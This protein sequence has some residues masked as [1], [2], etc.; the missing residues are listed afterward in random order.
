MISIHQP[1]K[2]KNLYFLLFDPKKKKRGM[3]K[4]VIQ[5]QLYPK[6]Q[7]AMIIIQQRKW[8]GL[9]L[10]L[11]IENFWKKLLGHR[12]TINPPMEKRV[13]IYM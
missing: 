12:V 2:N 5:T 9:C 8:C 13:Y 10:I 6:V 1:A 4:F 11:A 3:M 7:L